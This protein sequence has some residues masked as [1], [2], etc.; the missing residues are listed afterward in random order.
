MKKNNDIEIKKLEKELEDSIDSIDYNLS[1]FELTV[2]NVMVDKEIIKYIS[3]LREIIFNYIDTNNKLAISYDIFNINKIVNDM[4][5]GFTDMLLSGV[6]IKDNSRIDNKYFFELIKKT[7]FDVGA[8]ISKSNSINNNT[9]IKDIRINYLKKQLNNILIKNKMKGIISYDTSES[10]I[11]EVINY[12]SFNYYQL[13]ISV[14]EPLFIE[15][16]K[17]M[18]NIS[19][20]KYDIEIKKLSL[21]FLISNI[22]SNLCLF[23]DEEGEEKIEEMKTIIKDISNTENLNTVE[24][25]L[26][27][28]EEIEFSVY[29]Y[30]SVDIW[31]KMFLELLSS[32]NN[33]ISNLSKTNNKKELVRLKE[34]YLNLK[35]KYYKM[36]FIGNSRDIV[37]VNLTE[38]ENLILTRK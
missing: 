8:I 37:D 3:Y 35:K 13:H 10:K 16:I 15:T 17:D 20:E 25:I 38:V 6:Y 33:I 28:L 31:E 22:E 4:Y 12:I 34:L 29:D 23:L 26:K 5:S 19:Y 27:Y 2:N 14:I 9:S 30:P 7:I 11:N 1:I 36:I 24:M 21:Y 18:D 32:V